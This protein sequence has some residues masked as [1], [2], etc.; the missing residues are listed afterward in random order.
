MDGTPL[1]PRPLP[2]AGL[3]VVEV[4]IALAGPFAGSLLA[5]MGAE[6]I[7]VERRDGG[8]PMRLLGRRKN[9]VQVW[10]GVA[11][12]NKRVVTL[13]LKDPQGK[14]LFEQLVTDADVVVENYRP[15]VMDRLGIGWQHLSKI[16]PRLVMLSV[17]GFGQTG[18]DSGR[19]GFGKIAEAL[20]GMVTL[21]GEPAETP[22]HVGFSLADTSAGLMGFFA[23]AAALHARDCGGGSGTHIDLALY[24]PLLRMADCQLALHHLQQRSP[25]RQGSN[26]PYGWGAAEADGDW[27][28][29][30]ACADGRWL[31]LLVR[32]GG[33]EKLAALAGAAA[34]SDRTGLATAL[35]PWFAGQSPEAALAALAPL[36]IEAALVHDGATLATD[37]YFLARG[38]VV[39]TED[40]VVG[41]VVVPGYSPRGYDQS[42]LRDFRDAQVA[43]NNAE[44]LGDRLGVGRDR[45][46]ALEAAGT[47]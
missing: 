4:G 23:V 40:A 34:D 12:R 37:P 35:A 13:N 11:A 15:G 32:P 47:I 18:P 7:K 30:F 19:P 24:E 38:D 44:I 33:A 31:M 21:T 41:P 39:P 26:D 46:A 25:A 42:S 3:R 28:P 10:W 14:A 29:S 8:D 27:L 36:G 45:L 43:E 5:D 17:S 1:A 20:S 22:Q 2:L 16:N 9:G 6:V